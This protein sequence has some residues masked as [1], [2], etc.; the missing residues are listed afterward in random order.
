MNEIELTLLDQLNQLGVDSVASQEGTAYKKMSTSVTMADAREF[1]R[2][3]IGGE[4]WD[5]IECAP[6]EDRHQRSGRQGG[7]G[8]AGYQPVGVL[9]HRYQEKIMSNNIV[10]IGQAK[11][12]AAMRERLQSGSAVNKN[13]SD[14]IVDSFPRLSIRGKMFRIRRDGKELLLTDPLQSGSAEPRRGAGQRQPHDRQD[15]L[16]EGLRSRRRRQPA[17][18]LVAGLGQARPVGGQQGQPD[19][20][21]LPD[22]RL[23]L[24]RQRTWWR[25]ACRQGVLGQPPHC[26]GDAGRSRRSRSR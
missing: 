14:G 17:R 8:P 23:R 22:E 7:A 21:R 13:F 20:R 26:G 5:L 24:A 10:P 16:R 11:M 3:V 19:L 6:V 25:T 4:L 15:L 12:P 18:L 9:H 2:H 1:R